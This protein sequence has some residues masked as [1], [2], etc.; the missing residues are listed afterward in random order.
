MVQEGFIEE[1]T[2][3]RNCLDI[4]RTNSG[5]GIRKYKTSGGRVPLFQAN[6]RE[7]ARVPGEEAGSA[8]ATADGEERELDI[9]PKVLDLL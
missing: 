4:W 6:Y 5:R 3:E 8:K 2:L 7:E 1:V 9:N